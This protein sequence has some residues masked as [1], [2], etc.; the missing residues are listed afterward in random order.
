LSD[1]NQFDTVS[2]FEFRNISSYSSSSIISGQQQAHSL[3]KISSLSTD[4]ERE[5]LGAQSR[6]FQLAKEIT[7]GFR[8]VEIDCLD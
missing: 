3:S 2:D 7:V 8:L 5:R 1:S 4:E 6:D